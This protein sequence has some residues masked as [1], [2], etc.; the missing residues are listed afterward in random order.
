VGVRISLTTGEVAWV[1]D[2]DADLA[3]LSWQLSTHGHLKRNIRHGKGLRSNQELA[4]TI[5]ERLLARQAF[6]C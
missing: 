6:P 3:R 5:M 4:R 2:E 1:S